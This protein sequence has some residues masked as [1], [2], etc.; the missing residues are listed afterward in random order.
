MKPGDNEKAHALVVGAVNKYGAIYPSQDLVTLVAQALADERAATWDAAIAA[1]R[2]SIDDYVDDPE[3]VTV[4]DGSNTLFGMHR[5]KEALVDAKA[6]SIEG[7]RVK[8]DAG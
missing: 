6:A 7:G 2:K 3:D 5:V 8:H 4:R 1:A